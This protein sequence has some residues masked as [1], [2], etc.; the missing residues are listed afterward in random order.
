MDWI[1][2]E[3]CVHAREYNHRKTLNICR[4]MLLIMFSK[5]MVKCTEISALNKHSVL[6]D[7]CSM[8]SSRM[9]GGGRG[10]GVGINHNW[11][12]VVYFLLT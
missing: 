4:L 11:K 2:I 1:L 6:C 3:K 12:V 8:L 9:R 10:R 7:D 5:M